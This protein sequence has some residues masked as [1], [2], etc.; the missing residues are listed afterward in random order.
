MIPC[1]KK[2][3]DAK[4]L[5]LPPPT[6]KMADDAKARRDPAAAMKS[7]GA[8]FPA[9]MGESHHEFDWRD[10]DDRAIIRCASKDWTCID[11][12]LGCAAGARRRLGDLLLQARR[13]SLQ[14]RDL[15]LAEQKRTGE[16]LG[17]L[18]VRFGWLSRAELVA[19]LALQERQNGHDGPLR[20]GNILVAMGLISQ[21]QLREAMLQQQFCHKRLGE[22]L[23]E[24]GHVEARDI[25][26]GLNVQRM[27]FKAAL[28]ALL[29]L[30]ILAA[31]PMAYAGGSASVGVSATVRAFSKLNVLFQA[32]RLT[33][34]LEDIDRGYMDVHAGSRIEVKSNS[35]DGFTLTFD[36]I[37]DLFHAVQI[38]GLG[39]IVELGTEGGTVVQRRHGAQPASL[40]LGYRFILA[41][42]VLPGNYAW[43]L[44]LSAHPL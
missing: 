4:D 7:L 40:Q 30:A 18:L 39:G 22:L 32:H 29:S 28:T 26:R 6:A 25:W 17:D 11:A 12:V 27:L 34:D 20:L 31:A 15:C 2:F 24:A 14:Q 3:I 5:M 23:V 21:Q 42:N 8:I 1:K 19:V 37:L 44:A 10:L 41:K 16:R 38:T 35:Q 9:D 36:P 13:V 33:I 43:P